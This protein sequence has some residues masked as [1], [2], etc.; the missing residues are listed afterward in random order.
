[1]R[2]RCQS[3]LIT[4]VREAWHIVEPAVEFVYGDVIAAICQHLEAVERGEITRLLTNV[5][6]GFSKSIVTSVFFPA[7]VWG[8]CGKP[9]ARFLCTAHAQNLAIR[10]STKMRRLV[11]SQFYREHWPEVV[12]TGDQNSK[13]KFENDKT[14]FREA[15]AAGSITGSRGDFIIVDDPHSVEGATS[16]QMRATTIEWFSQALPTRLNNPEKSAIIV[17]MQRLHEGDVSGYILEN[18]LGYTHLCLPME[19]ES[20]RHCETEIGFSDWRT[21]EGELLFPER[22]PL[23]VVQRDKNILGPYGYSG[24]FQQRPSP[25]GGG[26][27]KRQWWGLWDDEAANA[28]GAPNAN[29]YPAFD[30]V[31]VSVDTAMSEKTEADESA[32]TVWGLWQKSGASATAV[33]TQHG[34]RRELVDEQDTI[35]AVM[36]MYAVSGRWTLHNGD[37]EKDPTE[38]DA[39]FKRRKMSNMGLVERI[40]D[41][42]GKFKANRVIVENKANGIT[43]GQEIR[44]LNKNSNWDVELVDPKGLDKIAR[45]YAIVPIFSNGAVY[46]PDKEWAE[47]VITQCEQFPMGNHDDLVDTCTQA[48]RWFRERGMLERPEEVAARA[49]WETERSNRKAPKPLYNV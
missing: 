13:L 20:D 48:L 17:I 23:E 14:G 4:F 35:P 40:M 27:L 1:M 7:W 28:T 36:L 8:P 24:Q 37:L 47:K 9:H 26:I 21:E 15:A 10:D 44:R 33:L 45:A 18:Q 5:P 41:L 31:I 11:S 22:F 42:A 38:T 39:Q 2:R 46:C 12:L 29:V 25:K 43:V 6:P 30:F 32:I 49:Q 3:S 34:V 16:D 19:Y